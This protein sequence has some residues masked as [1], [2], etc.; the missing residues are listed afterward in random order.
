MSS[1]ARGLK[2]IAED[3]YMTPPWVV[4]RLLERVDFPGGRW[5]EPCAGDGE[6]VRAVN[7][8]RPD[9]SWSLGELRE[10][11][12]LP[13]SLLADENLI[14]GDFLATAVEDWG[15]EPFD[16]TL[17]NPP[18]GLALSFIEKSIQFSKHTAMLLRLNFWG[19]EARQKFLRT[20]PPSTYVLPN[21]PVFSLNKHGKPGTD[22]P[23]YAWFKWNSA[24]WYEQN[25][26]AKAT[27]EVL[28]TTPKEERKAW[29]DRIR[30]RASMP[31]PSSSVDSVDWDSAP[32]VELF[33]SL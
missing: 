31:P 12:R 18:F 23:E 19:S 2:R 30:A 32:A 13:L 29:T 14:M 26:D 20:Y 22:S 28:N 25:P 5:L 24:E 9:I 27:I 15:I 1:T 3:A 8:Y 33:K 10:G 4:T 11:M 17:T 7:A 6:I 16:V 21:R